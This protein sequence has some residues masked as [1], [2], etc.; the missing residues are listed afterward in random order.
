M[1]PIPTGAKVEMM[2]KRELRTPNSDRP[3][4]LHGFLLGPLGVHAQYKFQKQALR[5]GASG[6]DSRIA[7]QSRHDSAANSRPVT[8]TNRSES[9][10][11]EIREVR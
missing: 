11:S 7:R 6:P 1:F 10:S 9:V 4:W 2:I 3:S 8:R 5:I